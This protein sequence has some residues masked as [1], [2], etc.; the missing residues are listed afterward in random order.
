MR[1]KLL[2]SLLTAALCGLMITA[3]APP[4]PENARIAEIPDGAIEPAV[5]GKN[6]PEQYETWKATAQPTPEGKSKYKR[7]NDGGKVYDRL[8]E[9]PFSALL[10]N[11]WGFG[12]EYNEPRGHVYMMTDQKE[13]DPSRLKGG[14]AC[15]TCKSPYASLL[16]EKQGVTYFAQT[17]EESLNQLPVEHQELGVACIDCHN[18]KDMGLK[19]ERGFTLGKALDKLGVDKTKLTN[20]D[21]RSL[22]CAQCH[23]TYTIP[24][25]DDMKS[26]DVFFPWDESQW[27]NIP[28]ENI[29]K[30]ML[31]DKSYGEWTQAVTGFKLPYIRHPEFEMYSTKSVHWMAGVSC[32]DCHMPYTKVGSKKISDHRIMS[33]LKND[34]KAC[35]QCHSQPAEWLKEQVITIQDRAASQFIRSGYAVATVAKLF[36]LTHK[37][38]ADGINIDQNM[39]N[40][41]KDH[42]L[43]A[44]FRNLFFGAENS[45][46]FHN[47]TEAMRI[48]AD[49]TMHAGKAEALL[50]QALTKAGVD[51]PVKI[52]LE[53]S[54]Y[55][56]N[57]GVRKLMFRPDQEF[58]DPYAQK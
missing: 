5:W 51:V 57:R 2:L 25:S 12:I 14:G 52:D 18:N 13:I 24:K 44:F 22:V 46:G 30:K 53:L 9:Y 15:L 4:K 19:I 29:I 39:Y 54:K 41:A 33:P 37:K 10:F 34:F 55:T 50:R 7:G 56:D 17:Y 1:S 45:M 20:Q 43:Q 31:S 36:E 8:S 42:Y 58:K 28:I 38:Q 21:K 48:L 3:C 32:A 35:Q 27:G 23:V 40:L 49:S 47:P 26:Q 6:Y 11:G 16:A